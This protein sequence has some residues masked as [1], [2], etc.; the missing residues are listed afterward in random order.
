MRDAANRAYDSTKIRIGN[1]C[2]SAAV[3][4]PSALREHALEL[5]LQHRQPSQPPLDLLELAPLK[6]IDGIA[7]LLRAIRQA[8]QLVDRLER[9]TELTAVAD[10]GE[11]VNMPLSVAALV[12]GDAGRL[13]HEPDLLVVADRLHLAAC[14][15]RKFANP[16]FPRRTC[17]RPL[18][19]QLL[20]RP[21]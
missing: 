8:E 16:D 20:Q 11:P 12:A 2:V 17:D 6:L 1:N 3:G 19:L 4:A 10:E 18:N 15:G 21:D 7:R 9:E 5:A 13:G 14:R